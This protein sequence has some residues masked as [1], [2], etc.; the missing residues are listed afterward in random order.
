MPVIVGFAVG[1]ETVAELNPAVGVHEYVEPTTA[2]APIVV[3]APLHI[4]LFIPTF[5]AGKFFIVTTTSSIELGQPAFVIVH[6]KEEDAPLINP[7]TVDD[8]FVVF[9]IVPTPLITVQLPLPAVAVF[10]DKVA[11][12]I[13][14]TDWSVP[15]L[16]VVIRH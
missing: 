14:Q 6:L 16:A 1:C 9:V 11:L 5:A 3:D 7:V 15:A 4:V 12:V 13:P 8:E 2:A 10:P